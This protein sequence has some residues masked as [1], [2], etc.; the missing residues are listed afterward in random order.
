MI[1][2]GLGAVGSLSLAGLAR[3]VCEGVLDYA[4]RH[5]G[6]EPLRLA[7]VLVGGSSG[8]IGVADAVQGIVRGVLA[9]DDLLRRPGAAIAIDRLDLVE[10]WEHRALQAVQALDRLAQDPELRQRLRAAPTI[11]AGENARRAATPTEP[12]G[13]WQRLRISQSEE[14]LTFCPVTDRA[15]I[16]LRTVATR[17]SEVDRLVRMAVGSTTDRPDLRRGL[18]EMLVPNQLKERAAEQ[19]G[20]ILQV[21]PTAA[22]YPWE[23]LEHRHGQ[24]AG[25]ET[26]PTVVRRPLLRQLELPGERVRERPRMVEG[27]DVLVIGDPK[28]PA[29]PLPGAQREARAVADRLG[30]HFAVTGPLVQADAMSVLAALHQRPYRLLHLAGHGDFEVAADGKRIGGM[31]LDGSLADHAWLRPAAVEQLAEVPE[32]VFINCC[33]LGQI[34][35]AIPGRLA[36]NL[37]E[38]FIRMGVRAVVAAG[39]TVNDAAALDFAITFYDAL[40]EGQTFGD[41]VQEARK[42][43]FE[44]HPGVNTWGAYQ[45]YGDPGFRLL[46]QDRAAAPRSEPLHSTGE[47][48]YILENLLAD[49]R[50]RGQPAA[51]LARLDALASDLSAFRNQRHWGEVLLARARLLGAL[52]RWDEA[53]ADYREVFGREDGAMTLRDIE[54]FV[55]LAVRRAGACA[56]TAATPAERAGA[57]AAIDQGLALLR[58]MVD[59]PVDGKRDDD[60]PGC[61]M[62]RLSL[63]ASAQKRKVQLLLLDEQDQARR[64]LSELAAAYGRAA[65]LARNRRMPKVKEAYPRLNQRF[66]EIIL[67]RGRRRQQSNRQ[68][69]AKDL[70]TLRQALRE[71]ADFWE[72]AMQVDIELAGVLGGGP[73]ALDKALPDLTRR[74]QAL[75]DR[76]SPAEYDSVVHELDFL[77][78]VAAL[79]SQDD[80]LAAGLRRIYELTKPPPNA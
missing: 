46:N 7:S 57:V 39:W 26:R 71:P 54:Q 33:H 58:W 22:A 9:A 16:E 15:R 80:A 42:K 78:A 25:E 65:D 48:V 38:Q 18:F 53:T 19:E 37:A 35:E 13:W 11:L 23:L 43:V 74:Y 68:D 67:A 5:A 44:Q 30:R 49:L 8:G 36:A 2:V 34:A 55:N 1:V 70:D 17:L 66:I 45:C 77:A 3:S 61:T 14:G 27:R 52:K 51:V 73:T 6:P 59:A 40:L 69:I 29:V 4:T 62:E 50:T 20:L 12:P 24:T 60:R 64:A 32:L 28:G 76:G 21:D 79:R 56:A 10:L 31:I 41:A 72:E 47:A 63:I 75:R